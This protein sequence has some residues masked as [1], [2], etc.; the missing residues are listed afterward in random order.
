MP[1]VSYDSEKD[2]LMY[3]SNKDLEQEILKL[4]DRR[5]TVSAPKPL[6]LVKEHV[7]LPD[8]A[9]LTFASFMDKEAYRFSSNPLKIKQK[10]MAIS[11]KRNIQNKVKISFAAFLDNEKN[12]RTG[13]H[14][15]LGVPRPGSE[16]KESG[17]S[18]RRGKVTIETERAVQEVPEVEGI[19][20]PRWQSKPSPKNG[21]K[22]ITTNM[23]TEQDLDKEVE[24]HQPSENQS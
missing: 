18:S 2:K 12:Y 19:V 7:E 10:E 11:Q 4:R 22:R 13:K 16:Y 8:A 6:N 3:W 24:H 17:L 21:R 20:T 9:K 23:L 14:Q 1:N 5:D 15:K